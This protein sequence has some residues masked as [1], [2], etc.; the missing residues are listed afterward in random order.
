MFYNLA[1][2]EI[3]VP[4]ILFDKIYQIRYLKKKKKDVPEDNVL[5]KI[6]GTYFFPF[7]QRFMH[8]VVYFVQFHGTDIKNKCIN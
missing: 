1:Q 2:A 8:F 6:R 7:I 4:I 3:R 5:P